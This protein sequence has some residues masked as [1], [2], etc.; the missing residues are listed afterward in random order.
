MT[1]KYVEIEIY[2]PIAYNSYTIER[3]EVSNLGHA[4]NRKTGKILVNT[5]FRTLKTYRKLIIKIRT[6]WIRGL[7][8][9]SG[10]IAD[11]T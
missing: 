7:A 10:V 11:I 3:Y 9:L 5:F 8:T 1:A 2:K 4:R 6:R